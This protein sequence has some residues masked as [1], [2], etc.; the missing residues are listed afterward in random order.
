MTT[1][2]EK[3]VSGRLVTR[4]INACG[5]VVPEMHLPD[6]L[7]EQGDGGVFSLTVL[8]EDLSGGW[9]AESA[10]AREN[11][12]VCVLRHT[13][14]PLKA[15]VLSEAD[16]TGWITR[17]LKLRNTGDRALPIEAL[18]PF[19]GVIFRHTF[20]N[21]ILSYR[22]EECGASADLAY[23]IGYSRCADWGREGDFA[24]RRLGG[25]GLTFDSGFHGRCG[26]SRPSYVLKDRL[27]GGLFAVEFAYSGNWRLYAAPEAAPSG[28]RLRHGIGLSTPRGEAARVLGPGESVTA[29]AVCFTLCAQGENALIQ[30]RHAF[31]RS[32]VLP[33]SDPAGGALI[34]ANHRGYLCDRESEEGILRDMEVAAAAGAELYVIDAGW[35]GNR[36]NNWFDNAGDWFAGEWLPHDLYPLIRRARSAGMKFG[37]WMEAEA[38]GKNSDLRKTHPEFL[39]RRYGEP[40]ADG[41]ALDFSN[42][43]VAAY[44]E[45][46]IAD[47]ITRYGLDMFRTDHN[48]HLLEGGTREVSGYVENLTW[49]YYDN[50]YGM[51]DRLRERFKNVSFQNCAAGGGRL[52]I[53][54]LSHFHNTEI[55][56]WARP[57]R[58]AK[59]FSGMLAQLPPEIMLRICGTEVGE[60]V[61][62]SDILSSLHSA[63]Q[64]R[65]IFR[66]IAPSAGE[67]NPELISAIGSA[68]KLYKTE[69]RPILTGGCRVFL[70]APLK[71]VLEEWDW[72]AN[73]FAL[74][75]R[76][77]AFAVVQKLSASPEGEFRLRFD[78]IDGGARYLVRFDRRKTECLLPG[79][80]LMFEGL[81]LRM[82]RCL[83]TE[84]IFVKKVG[85]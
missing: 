23:E 22:P 75:D 85:G 59:I 1:Y 66:G 37:L 27:S 44:V 65:M 72:A 14:Y 10:E 77:A 9:E 73:E 15:T 39:L 49:R 8:G 11:A 55:S 42:P 57:P 48:H 78:G 54:A 24:Y 46:Q 13:K 69:L 45:G 21:G 62:A 53:G 5:Q 82:D 58:D 64:G 67:A 26:W 52:D 79:S 20:E 84:L 83:E 51:F 4:Y 60:H 41:R 29:P 70:H 34:E 47:A 19:R 30:S 81:A 6:S 80:A 36:P 31:I 12:A 32:R 61:Q 74:P 3:V 40:V 16:G 68:V 2:D 7:F 35:F 43:E 50:L 33:G 38:A 63:M 17:T 76:S 18:D 25:D 28:I 71:G 56:D